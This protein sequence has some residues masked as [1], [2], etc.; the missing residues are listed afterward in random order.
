M[1]QSYKLLLFSQFFFS[2]LTNPSKS[3][4]LNPIP[5]NIQPNPTNQN[6]TTTTTLQFKMNSQNDLGDSIMTQFKPVK[7]QW[8]LTDD[9]I[10]RIDSKTGETILHN[11]CKY[12]NTTPLE[13]YQYLIETNCCNVQAQDKYN[14]TP[15]HYL[16]QDFH[17]S[18][19][20]D[21]DEMAILTYLLHQKD[22]DVNIKGENGHTL[23]HHACTNINLL[24]F[25]I[26]TL[27][28]E[29]KGADGNIQD[30]YQSTPI[31]SAL[32]GFDPDLG[33]DV[34]VLIYLLNQKDV[35]IS[36]QNQYSCTLF[37]QICINLNK[38]PFDIFKLLVE[39]KSGD[40]NLRDDNN[41]T[42]FDY[43]LQQ[44]RPNCGNTIFMYLIDQ[45]D[46][47]INIE[48]QYCLTS[49]HSVCNQDFAHRQDDAFIGDGEKDTFLS[50]IVE[51]IIEKIV[52]SNF[53]QNNKII[54]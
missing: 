34:D 27:M 12:I 26:F 37:H 38:F 30:E 49:L 25:D 45:M 2:L 16:L 23:F 43:A 24:P 1:N 11:Y 7:G 48:D 22:L 21:G 53:A 3:L 41:L 31:Q 18:L 4:L 6:K 20:G 36:V 29:I 44:F 28:I 46:V 40:V 52:Q 9:N 32:Y 50:Q 42:P 39:T 33:G 5:K 10:K 35:M 19:D 14:N 15:C 54:R 13:V 8:K 51:M 47:N 17:P